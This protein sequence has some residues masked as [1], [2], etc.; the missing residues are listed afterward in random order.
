[1]KRMLLVAVL[2]TAVITGLATTGEASRHARKSGATARVAAAAT[3]DP[4]HCTG[5]CPYGG[6]GAPAKAASSTAASASVKGSAACP[7]SDPSQCPPSCRP[8]AASAVAS[9]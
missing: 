7:V 8:A 5:P 3:C 2:A 9:R 4:S 1:M 6:G